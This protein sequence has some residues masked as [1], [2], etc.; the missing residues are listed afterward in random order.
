MPVIVNQINN[1]VFG[2]MFSLCYLSCTTWCLALMKDGKC[3]LLVILAVVS[4]TSQQ[5]TSIQ[6][7]FE[8]SSVLV[9][10]AS[11]FSSNSQPYQTECPV[12]IGSVGKGLM[13]TYTYTHAHTH[14]HTHPRR[15]I[16]I[17][18]RA[19]TAALK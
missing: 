9:V 19:I 6:Q 1:Y 4:P 12:L 7:V 18:T 17:S 2:R 8:L 14:A 11:L 5:S 15:H 13:S 16:D 3:E 10:K